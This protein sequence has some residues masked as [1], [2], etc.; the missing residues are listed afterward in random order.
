[1]SRG[2]K[3]QRKTK[4]AKASDNETKVEDFNDEEKVD[5]EDDES[6][7]EK[8]K[9]PNDGD[10]EDDKSKPGKGKKPNNGDDSEEESDEE[11]SEEE[12]ED[13]DNSSATSTPTSGKAKKPKS[14]KTFF[15]TDPALAYVG[16]LQL[17]KSNQLKIYNKG[18]EAVSSNPFDATPD[19]LADF[20]YCLKRRA[21]D[22]GWIDGPHDVMSIKLKRS[23]AGLSILDMHAKMELKDIIKHDERIIDTGHTREAQNLKMLYKCIEA[24]LSQEGRTRLIPKQLYYCTVVDG[25]TKYLGNAYLKCLL[26]HSTVDSVAGAWAIKVKFQHLDETIAKYKYNIVRFNEEVMNLFL[27]LRAKGETS[28]DIPFQLLKAYSMVPCD[29]WLRWLDRLRDD[30]ENNP[31]LMNAEHIVRKA[32]N[33][34][35]RLNNETAWVIKDD[36]QNFHALSTEIAKLKQRMNGKNGKRGDNGGSHKNT[37][38]RVRTQQKGGGQKRKVQVDVTRKPNPIDKVQTFN[39]DNWYWCSKETGGTCPGIL[40]KHNPKD[41]QFAERQKQ[42]QANASGGKGKGNKSSKPTLHAKDVTIHASD[43]YSDSD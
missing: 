41:C 8:E 28:T 21:A 5:N 39:G 37:K 40:R 10:N 13:E 14:K 34:Y 22:Y 38:K 1:M 43:T 23:G 26:E 31:A 32:D 6:I 17:R 3:A 27:E 42:R 33:Q 7:S 29:P 12:S 16:V 20:M 36:E 4:A 19:Q 35:K 30:L 24:S 25:C 9:Q 11:D 2:N 15:A 18:C